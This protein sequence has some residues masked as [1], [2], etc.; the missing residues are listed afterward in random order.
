MAQENLQGLHFLASRPQQLIVS[1]KRP[2]VG[3]LRCEKRE[4]VENWLCDELLRSCTKKLIRKISS[5]SW[6]RPWQNEDT[7]WR[8]HSILRRCPSVAKRGNI[9]ARRADTRNVSE[10][11][12]KHFM[13]PGHKI[14]VRHKCCARGKTR[15]HLGNMITSAMLP[16]QCVLVFPGPYTFITPSIRFLVSMKLNVTNTV[17]VSA[18]CSEVLL[19]KSD[20]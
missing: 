10:D 12:Q 17:H 9:V 11:V 2:F 1:L 19:I 14:C 4:A 18:G 6:V 15:T 16:P 8:Q 20:Y 13:Y 5:S 7:L 3:A